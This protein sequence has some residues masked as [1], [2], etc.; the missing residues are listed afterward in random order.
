MIVQEAKLT[1]EA[2]RITFAD[3]IIALDNNFTATGDF[4]VDDINRR[5][6]EFYVKTNLIKARKF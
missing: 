4:F 5:S 6:I 2:S 3:I 1:A